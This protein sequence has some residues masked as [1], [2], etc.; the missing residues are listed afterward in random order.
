MPLIQEATTR[1]I[2]RANI[3]YLSAKILTG[4]ASKDEIK[5]VVD[6]PIK[7]GCTDLL[8]SE[9]EDIGNIFLKD[10]LEEKED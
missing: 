5:Q 2:C 8:R 9:F 6:D 4:K 1:D 3:Y 7:F 10:S